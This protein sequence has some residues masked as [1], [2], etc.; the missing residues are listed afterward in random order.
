MKENSIEW[1]NGQRAVTVSLSQAKF[2]NKVKK[3]AS[4]HPEVEILAENEDGS[5]YA[6]LPLNYIKISAP[7]QMSE[8]QKQKA[9]ERLSAHARV[10]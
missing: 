10:I 1:I 5:I 4:D 6:H 8:D 3:L 9:R 2:I 7:R